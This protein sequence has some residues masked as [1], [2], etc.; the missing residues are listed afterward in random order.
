MTRVAIA[1]DYLTQR[2][3]AERVVLSLSRAFPDAPIHTSLYEPSET[4]AEYQGLDVRVSVLNRIP[5]LRH[6]HR[7]AL[8]F[9]A[10][11]L[12][13]MSTDADVVICN[14][15][16]WSHGIRA[17]GA[18]IVYCH[19]PA[20]WLYQ[21][22]SYTRESSWPTKAALAVVAAPLR[23]WDRRAARSADLYLA[24]STRSQTLIRDAYGF[25]TQILHPPH[26]V[27][28]D[29]ERRPVEGLEPGFFLCV[30]RLLPYKNVEL[31]LAGFESLPGERLVI[32]GKGPDEQRL[33]ALAPPN[34]SFLSDIDD[35]ELRWL[36]AN[37]EA[38]VAVGIEDFGLTPVEAAAFG[39]PAIVVPFGGY[40]DTVEDGVN[41]V[42]LDGDD[43]EALG[44]AIARLRALGLETSRIRESS[45]PFA[46]DVFVDRIRAIVEGV[47]RSRAVGS[48]TDPG[49]LPGDPA[50][51]PR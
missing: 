19:A 33:R 29:A 30:S 46:E 3:G 2:G 28:P 7:L 24:N 42:H 11:A 17:R 21:R 23:I 14:T 20:R 25:E 48:A 50:E 44:R 16:G 5:L 41:G 8:P 1:H 43:P 12:S 37:A 51:S 34:S 4:F 40:L 18:K 35:A 6:R 27:D 32:V 15:T 45:A 38:L 47:V 26:R 13:S 31:A 39:T 36:Y 49:S 10:P 9:L 22:D